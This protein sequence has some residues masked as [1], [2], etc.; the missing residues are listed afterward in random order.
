MI[1]SVLITGA[2]SGLGK[3]TARQLALQDQSEKIYLACRNAERAEAAKRSLEQSTGKSIFEIILTDVS[4][5]ESVKSAVESLREPVDALVMNAGGMG[6]RNP[7]E[8]TVDGVIQLFAVNVL[9]HVVLFDELLKANKLIKVALYAGSEAARGVPKMGMKR[10][11][12]ET[13]SVDEFASICDGSF[14]GGKVDPMEAYGPV[15]YVATMWMS[16]VARKNQ[17]MRIVTMS[18]GGTGGTEVMNDLPPFKKFMFKH[19]GTRL[20][21]MMGLMHKLEVGAKRFVDGLNDESYQSGV[22]YGSKASVLTG[23]LIDQSTLFEDLKNEVFQ[24]NANEAIHR[25][26]K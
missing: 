10:P 12:L 23:S 22:F 4:N 1:K 9:G 24:D 19:I 16:S 8:K 20:M 5:L 26:S 6:G 18:P 25:F 2:N 13:S 17:N 21:P 14:F 11:N 15:K 3:E 7:G